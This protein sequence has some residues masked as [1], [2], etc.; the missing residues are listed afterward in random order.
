MMPLTCRAMALC[1]PPLS[2]PPLQRVGVEKP[3]LT[4][5]ELV[6][7]LPDFPAQVLETRLIEA[8]PLF[9]ETQRL[10]HDFACGLVEAALKLIM[11]EL[12]ELGC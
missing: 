11:D 8:I 9:Q 1:E 5:V 2:H 6:E 10:T 7:P 4:S 3:P 12:G